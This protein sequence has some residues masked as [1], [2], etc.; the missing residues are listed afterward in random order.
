MTR[1]IR[2]FGIIPEGTGTLTTV[3]SYTI[4]SHG[5]HVR[6]TVSDDIAMLLRAGHLTGYSISG[7][8]RR[9]A[10]RA[11]TRVERFLAWLRA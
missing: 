1:E 2:G 10:H 7:T 3:D 4:D 8:R 9:P 11:P 5:I 6:G